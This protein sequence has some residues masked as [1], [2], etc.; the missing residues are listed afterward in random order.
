MAVNPENPAESVPEGATGSGVI[1]CASIAI[2][3]IG[4]AM[5]WFIRMFPLP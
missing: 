2:G 4:I 3:T 1:G 5:F